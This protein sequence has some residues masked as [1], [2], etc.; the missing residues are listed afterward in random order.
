MYGKCAVTSSSYILLTTT[1]AE[2][3]A[4]RKLQPGIND[5]KPALSL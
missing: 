5:K 2:T 1:V 4:Q 3:L